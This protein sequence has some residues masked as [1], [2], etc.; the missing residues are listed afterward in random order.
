[1]F[2]SEIKNILDT[3]TTSKV[4]NIIREAKFVDGR[5]SGGTER[6]KYNRELL[7]ESKTYLDV[8]QSHRSGCA[9]ELRI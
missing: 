8:L 2:I 6:S 4:F 5:I 3:E 1:M 7:P 9:R